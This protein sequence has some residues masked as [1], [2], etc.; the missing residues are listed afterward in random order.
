M[1]PVPI[2][3][4][5][6][7]ILIGYV[8]FAVLSCILLPLLGGRVGTPT[9]QRPAAVG[10]ER[11]AI[12]DD[13]NQ[14][15][16]YRLRVIEEADEQ[17]ILS[18]Y[19]FQ[20]DY[21][22]RAMIA[23]LK[24]AADRG[25]KI[26]VLVDGINGQRLTL[27]SRSFRSLACMDNVEVRLYNPI[28]LLTP[29]RTNYRLHDKY[30]IADNDVYILGGRNTKDLSLYNA[31]KKQDIDRD[32][33]VVEETDDVGNSIHRVQDYF[34]SVWDLPCC[35]TIRYK[36]TDAQKAVFQELDTQ[37]ADMQIMLPHVFTPTD[38]NAHTIPV[39]QIHFLSNPPQCYN[40]APLLWDSLME[41][42]RQSDHVLLQTPYIVC[43]DEM[44]HDIAKLTAGGTQLQILTNSPKSG[45]NAFGCSDYM[46]QKP[47]ILRTG[48][49]VFE[50][51]ANRSI[52]GKTALVDDHLSIV[53]SF[54][55][56]M[57]SAYLDTETMLVI[58]SPEINAQLRETMGECIIRSSHV[59]PDGSHTDGELYTPA[60]LPLWKT[61]YY[62]ILR[63]FS[64]PLRHLV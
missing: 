3:K 9:P 44:Y 61:L 15:L 64:Y 11:A 1:K 34:H 47:N 38:W 40:K 56:D 39:N 60:E 59:L 32:V 33:L 46:N 31:N 62:S 53:G 12:I 20:D 51:S 57:R 26:Q 5:L 10:T 21:S 2:K 30:L 18:T 17:I 58:D 24:Q 42:F 50:F 13:N 29:W 8:L 48:A 37:Y 16:L 55:T 19:S 45:A 27:T 28:N 54:N 6:K 52:H 63:V 49:E 41:I 25:V 22:G 7:Y 23:A 36:Q 43:S 14:A 35:K 4:L